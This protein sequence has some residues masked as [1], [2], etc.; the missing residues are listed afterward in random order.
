ASNGHI[1]DL[2][3]SKLGVDL[4]NDFEPEYVP[5]R[6]K[7]QALTRIKTAAQAAE[8]IY[9]AP[10]PDREGEAIAWHLAGALKNVRRPIQRL[11]FN[12]ITE[13]AVKQAIDAP[14]AWC[15]WG[16]SISSRGSCVTIERARRE[17]R[18][19]MNSPRWERP[20]RSEPTP[21]LAS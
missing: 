10:D 6:G 11:T 5:I 16:I 21:W 9:L 15:G 17:R 7:A 13:R 1:M 3:K 18:R 19:P 4:E 14:R 8:R 20:S 2:P 12:E